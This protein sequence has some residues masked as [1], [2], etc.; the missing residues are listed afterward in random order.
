MFLFSY[1]VRMFRCCFCWSWFTWKFGCS[2]VSLKSHVNLTTVETRW[3]FAYV[4]VFLCVKY[5]TQRLFIQFFSD[6]FSYPTF[7]HSIFMHHCHNQWNG[8]IAAMITLI[9]TIII[10]NCQMQNQLL[11]RN[12][13]GLFQ[14]MYRTFRTK[15]INELLRYAFSSFLEFKRIIE[16]D[17][18]FCDKAL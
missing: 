17:I 9:I 5:T 13:K 4:R 15:Q 2:V 6:Q 10:I 14:L 16:F 8:Y 11:S 12:N 18:Y 7:T 1:V 3:S